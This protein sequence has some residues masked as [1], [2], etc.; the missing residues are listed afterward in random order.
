MPERTN[1]IKM[2]TCVACVNLNPCLRV[3]S[4]RYFNSYNR[5]GI[6]SIF[7]GEEHETQ[8]TTLL[9]LKRGAFRDLDPVTSLNSLSCRPWSRQMNESLWSVLWIFLHTSYCLY[10][11]SFWNVI[12]FYPTC[13]R[14]L[15]AAR[16][17]S[18]V[19]SS[20][21]SSWAPAVTDPGSDPFLHSL[22]SGLLSNL[23]YCCL[24]QGSSLL[25][26]KRKLSEGRKSSLMDHNWGQS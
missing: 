9:G 5:K 12:S 13:Q 4:I 26:T 16:A 25:Q 23:S 8:R 2:L 24:L 3:P 6:L 22:T 18:Q 21:K 1:I 11:E 17:S 10:P 7:M 14:L 15:S 19:T 20:V